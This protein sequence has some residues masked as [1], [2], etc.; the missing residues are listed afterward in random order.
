MWAARACRLAEGTAGATVLVSTPDVNAIVQSAHAARREG[1]HAAALTAFEAALARQILAHVGLKV[2]AASELRELGR[3]DEAEALLRQVLAIQPKHV[4]AL[5]ELGY[6]ARRRGDRAA[7]LA[8]F[9]A[10]AAADPANV[11]MK[12]AAASE[13]REL[14]R[15][16]EAEALLRQALAIKPQH[17]SCACRAWPCGTAAGRSCGGAG[18]IR[19]S[20]GSRSSPCWNE[21]GGGVGVAGARASRRGGSAA[22]AGAGDSTADTSVPWP[23]LAMLHGAGAIVPA[24]LAAF[25]AAAAARSNPCWNEGGGCVRAAGARAS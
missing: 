15:L 13:L 25:E 10:A 24:A 14:G 23:S 21:G 11:G 8:A 16:D 17:V 18:G 20:S 5:A 3:L 6:V 4:S 1:D 19:G 22:A 12:V 9:E 7:A 2:S